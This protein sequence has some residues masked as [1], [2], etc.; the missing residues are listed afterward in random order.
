M[1]R[2]F[3]KP[4]KQISF[5]EYMRD[6]LL[7]AKRIVSDNGKQRYSSAQFEIALVSFADLVTLKQEMDD[8]IEVKFPKLEC[9]WTP[10]FDWL[11]LAVH[12]GDPDAIAYFKDNMQRKDFSAA[13]QYFKTYVRP[14]CD[15]ELYED[16]GKSYE[17]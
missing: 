16:K 12:Y 3:K 11:D 17:W 14:D 8:D 1:K 4:K 6:T 9:D 13:Y 5:E 2:F 10:G 15:L 7:I